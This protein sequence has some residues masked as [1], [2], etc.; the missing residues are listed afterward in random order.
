VPNSDSASTLSCNGYPIVTSSR[1]EEAVKIHTTML[2]VLLLPVVI[3]AQTTDKKTDEH[4]LYQVE[5]ARQ[6]IESRLRVCEIDLIERALTD[7]HTE[8]NLDLMDR[9]IHLEELEAQEV[10]ILK[11][12]GAT[13]IGEAEAPKA[14]REAVKALNAHGPQESGPAV[15]ALLDKIDADE[16]RENEWES[17]A[18]SPG[19]SSLLPGESIDMPPGGGEAFITGTIRTA[20][21]RGLPLPRPLPNSDEKIMYAIYAPPEIRSLIAMEGV[22]HGIDE[23]SEIVRF[24]GRVPE[25][26][27]L[28]ISW[29]PVWFDAEAI[30]CKY[31]PGAKFTDLNNEEQMC[32]SGIPVSEKSKR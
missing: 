26:D 10:K 28:I 19:A 15:K 24:N 3:Q 12:A 25:Y 27:S 23:Y 32:S 2:A 31:N 17:S 18:W 22:R 21:V 29:K 7:E 20:L 6:Q 9:L 30:F 16:R 5:A 14:T 4:I 1:M 8:V 13:E 11:G